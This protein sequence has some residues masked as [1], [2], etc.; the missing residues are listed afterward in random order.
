MH[1]IIFL[2]LHARL[3]RIDNF[4]NEIKL[5]CDRK[6]NIQ[7]I[8]LKNFWCHLKFLKLSGVICDSFENIKFDQ[9]KSNFIWICIFKLRY[10]SAN[11]YT[12]KCWQVHINLWN[13]CQVNYVLFLCI[14]TTSATTNMSFIY[15]FILITN[16]MQLPFFVIISTEMLLLQ[17]ACKHTDRQSSRLSAVFR[18]ASSKCSLFCPEMFQFPLASLNRVRFI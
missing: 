16:S 6:I 3:S 18:D 15:K 10:L 5:F 2:N 7:L 11:V 17:S 14:S 4:K 8:I 9:L 1:Y 13:L 12:Y